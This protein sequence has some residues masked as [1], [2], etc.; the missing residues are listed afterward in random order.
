M[1]KSFFYNTLNPILLSTLKKLMEAKIFSPFRL[2]GGTSLSLQLGHRQSVDID[3]FTDSEYSS[4]DFAAIDNYLKNNFN[5]I[6]SLNTS[7]IGM[8]K[9]Y[10]IG[11]SVNQCVKLDLFYTD[12]FIRPVL[13][14][15]GLR[16]A[17]LEDIAAM[18]LDVIARGGRK[19][20]FWDI[21]ELLETFSLEQMLNFHEVR[22]PWSHIK[23]EI[24]KK[25]VVFEQ[26]DSDFDPICL[27]NKYWELI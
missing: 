24:L 7:I 1:A 8:G 2:V 4:I 12:S 26:A 3:L 20:D 10:F 5:Y 9:S 22:Y 18:K 21:H 17:G 11:E 14:R 6:D 19:K 23:E 25:L 15:D 16:L 13:F 27:K